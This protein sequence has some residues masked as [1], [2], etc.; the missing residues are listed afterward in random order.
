V[1]RNGRLRQT[2]KEFRKLTVQLSLLTQ[3]F[4]SEIAKRTEV[5]NN[6]KPNNICEPQEVYRGDQGQTEKYCLAR[7]YDQQPWGR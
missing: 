6:E 2:C 1:D 5:K 7:S 4:R 3:V